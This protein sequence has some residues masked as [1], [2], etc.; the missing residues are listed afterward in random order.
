MNIPSM[1]ARTFKKHEREI[2]PVVE[3]IAKDSCAEACE[4]ERRL[5]LANLNEIKKRL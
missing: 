1:T 4:E 3:S 2:G 5:T